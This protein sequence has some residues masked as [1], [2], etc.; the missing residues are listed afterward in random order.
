MNNPCWN[1]PDREMHC[2]VGCERYAAFRTEREAVY[3]KRE[4]TER[5]IDMEKQAVKS[6]KIVRPA[7]IKRK[8]E[9]CLLHY[10]FLLYVSYTV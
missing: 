5:L 10:R 3:K 1:C 8:T 6:L 9:H 4:A 7:I 2:A